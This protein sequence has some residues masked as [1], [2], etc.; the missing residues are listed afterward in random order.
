MK[1]KYSF[2]LFLPQTKGA[3]KLYS[4]FLRPKLLKYQGDV[5]SG[6]SKIKSELKSKVI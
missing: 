2:R 4:G 5:D 6:L 1:K 3:Q